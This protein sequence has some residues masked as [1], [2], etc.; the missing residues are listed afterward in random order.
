MTRMMT[1]EEV[2]AQLDAA[3]DPRR[4]RDDDG[5]RAVS[6]SYDATAQRVLV[7]F[8]NGCLFG[9]R[10]SLVP[11][12]EGATPELLA[13]VQVEALGE[14]VGWDAL[15]AGT[16][17]RGLMLKTFRVKG[18]AARYMGSLTSPQKAAASREN[19]RKG[20]RPRKQAPEG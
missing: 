8:D 14:A 2:Q 18:W 20:G 16:D 13:Q 5:P 4:R 19:G 7:E 15:N 12:T 9:F 3:Y 6:A 17:V 11:G 1:E 10:V